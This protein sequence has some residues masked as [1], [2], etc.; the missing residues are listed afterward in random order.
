MVRVRIRYLLHLYTM[1]G[2]RED[3]IDTPP[4]KTSV[5]AVIDMLV[6]KYGSEFGRTIIDPKTNKLRFHPSSEERLKAHRILLNGV[7]VMLINGG[8]TSLNDGD[9]ISIY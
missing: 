3:L 9:I 1:I 6:D 8:K 2:H 5:R 7:N 4:D